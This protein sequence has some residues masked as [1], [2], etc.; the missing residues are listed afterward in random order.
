MDDKLNL[1]VRERE[2]LLFEGMVDALTS[3]N[4]VGPFDILPYHSNFVTTI[5]EKVTIHM[6]GLK[7]EIEFEKGLIRVTENKVEVYVGI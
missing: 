6:N 1:V 2:K 4:E 3:V 7:Q 5:R